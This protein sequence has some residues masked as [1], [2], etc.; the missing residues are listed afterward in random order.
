VLGLD[1]DRN[2]AIA[3][4]SSEAVERAKALVIRCQL[5][6]HGSYVKQIVIGTLLGSRRMW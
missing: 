6:A 3:H 5:A 4:V 2:V 1:I